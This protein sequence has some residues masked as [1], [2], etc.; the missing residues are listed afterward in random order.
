MTAAVGGP[1][2]LHITLAIVGFFE[3]VRFTHYSY[4][5]AIVVP[6]KAAYLHNAIA[7]GRPCKA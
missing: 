3:S 1:S 7:A 6:L 4:C 5:V 2:Y